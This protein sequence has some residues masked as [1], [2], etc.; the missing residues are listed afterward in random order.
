M[1]AGNVFFDVVIDYGDSIPRCAASAICGGCTCA[2]VR[3]GRAQPCSSDS[4][5]PHHH[6]GV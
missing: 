5:S 2:L 1:A 3:L 6:A 4:K